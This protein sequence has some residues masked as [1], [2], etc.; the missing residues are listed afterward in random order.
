MDLLPLFLITNSLG[1]KKKGKLSQGKP[2]GR[3]PQP[4]PY[5]WVRTI[6]VP[7]ILRFPSSVP[8][9]SLMDGGR[10]GPIRNF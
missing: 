8:S 10:A 4:H 3:P 5:S 1:K 7:Q 9:K 2:G 6:T